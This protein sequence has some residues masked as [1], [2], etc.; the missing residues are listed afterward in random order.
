MTVISILGVWEHA[1][2]LVVAVEGVPAKQCW[3]ERKD[4]HGPD[5]TP[6]NINS[7]YEC[8]AAC[9]NDSR[10]D[11]ID[12]EPSNVGKTCWI[13]TSTAI[14]ETTQLG[15]I[16][17][18][19]LDRTCLGESCFY[20]TPSAFRLCHVAY[21][22]DTVMIFSFHLNNLQWWRREDLLDS[23]INS[24][25]RNYAAWSYYELSTGSKLPGWVL[26]LRDYDTPSAF[27]LSRCLFISDT[28]IT[29]HFIQTT[30]N[31]FKII[32]GQCHIHCHTDVD[33]WVKF[34]VWVTVP[35]CTNRHNYW[36]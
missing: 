5:G 1:L 19:Q 17:N 26:L 7:L 25:Q 13:L 15:V 30:L 14:K 12:W 18:Y 29:S 21:S 10:C 24:H 28:V 11:A 4:F 23:N 27:R 2:Y 31:D 9:I 33:S 36:T 20:D 34:R 35:H 3:T 8:Q 16:T 22:S 6:H 32:V